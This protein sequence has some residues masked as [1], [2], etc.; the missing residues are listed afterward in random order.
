MWRARVCVGVC[1]CVC[2]GVC[3]AHALHFCG[4]PSWKARRKKMYEHVASGAVMFCGGKRAIV[5]CA[6]TREYGKKGRGGCESEKK[7][8][9][10]SQSSSCRVERNSVVRASFE[11]KR[12]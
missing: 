1:V 9:G 4:G 6:V 12:C 10:G 2:V 3:A 11:C 5:S 8:R 7:G